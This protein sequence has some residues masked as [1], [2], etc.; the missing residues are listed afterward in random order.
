MQGCLQMV[1]YTNQFQQSSV[2]RHDISP[3]RAFSGREVCYLAQV[4]GGAL[5]KFLKGYQQ[6]A[7]PILEEEMNHLKRQLRNDS[8]FV[9]NLQNIERETQQWLKMWERKK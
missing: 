7:I 9:Q 1:S 4:D 8:D 3:V 5:L 6:V 2:G